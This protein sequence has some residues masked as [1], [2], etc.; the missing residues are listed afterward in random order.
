MSQGEKRAWGVAALVAVALLVFGFSTDWTFRLAPSTQ[1]A[2][3]N[4]RMVKAMETLANKDAA[5]AST[6]Q[7]ANWTPPVEPEGVVRHSTR[8]ELPPN[9]Y[10]QN[11]PKG[12]PYCN[13]YDNGKKFLGWVGKG[14]QRHGICGTAPAT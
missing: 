1:T 4:E 2:S 12:Q 6:T 7:D 13:K 10:G 5:K 14:L 9:L 11:D 3:F 8:T